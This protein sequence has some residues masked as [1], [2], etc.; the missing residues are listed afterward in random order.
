MEYDRSDCERRLEQALRLLRALEEDIVLEMSMAGPRTQTTWHHLQIEL[1]SVM[2]NGYDPSPENCSEFEEVAEHFRL[3]L[4][5][6]KLE[7]LGTQA[8][9][10]A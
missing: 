2:C 9:A 10:E 3:F 8:S 5:Y 6:L 1:A 4:K 7:Q